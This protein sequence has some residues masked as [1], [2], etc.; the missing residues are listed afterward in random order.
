ME[1]AFEAE[2]L[3]NDQIALA[4]E[5][6]EREERKKLEQEINNFRQNYQRP[7]DR[8]EFDLNDPNYVKKSLPARLKDDDPRCGI[9]SAQKYPLLK[10]QSLDNIF[11]N[12]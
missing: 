7:E 11:C 9:S 3:K 10:I 8:R 5:Q 2:R 4:L 12:L 6:K 1:Q